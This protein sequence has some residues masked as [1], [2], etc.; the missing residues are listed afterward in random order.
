M[1]ATVTDLDVLAPAR[2]RVRLAGQ[3]YELPGDVPVATMLELE[4]LA[5]EAERG[6]M[7]DYE[8]GRLLY[9]QVLGIFRVHQPDIVSLP[10][11]IEQLAA[12]VPTV[13]GE[14]PPAE[15]ESA[16]GPTPP[17]AEAGTKSSGKG[18]P[19]KPPKRKAPSQS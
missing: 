3:E 5:Q 15:D 6:D 7:D 13:Y 18:K 4:R 8:A 2:K 1:P 9:E 17:Q 14:E 16:E 11:G 19:V 12:F 10:F